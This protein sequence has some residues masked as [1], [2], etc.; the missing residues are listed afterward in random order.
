VTAGNAS[1]IVDGAAG[2]GGDARKNCEGARVETAGTDRG[3]DDSGRATADHGDRSRAAI[4]KALGVG[5]LETRANGL[6]GSE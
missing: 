2:R 1:G 4:Q 6:G 5:G 3:L